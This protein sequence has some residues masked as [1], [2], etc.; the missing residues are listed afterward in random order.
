MAAA[1]HLAVERV[2][3]AAAVLAVVIHPAPVKLAQQ[4]SAVAA[5]AAWVS[6]VLLR[7]LVDLVALEL[8]SLVMH[9]LRRP[10]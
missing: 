8:S 1:A 9:Y 3:T 4:L 2:A 7:I 5:V 6:A 10:H